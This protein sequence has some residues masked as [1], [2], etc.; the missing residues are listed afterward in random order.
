MFILCLMCFLG[1]QKRGT[2]FLRIPAVK[3]KLHVL[4]F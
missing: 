4:F 1:G 2:A 3:V